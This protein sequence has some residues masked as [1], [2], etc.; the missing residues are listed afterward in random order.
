MDWRKFFD[1][2]AEFVDDAFINGV[3][4]GSIKLNNEKKIEQ[5]NKALDRKYNR[6]NK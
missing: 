1:G 5:Y 4:D 6:K 2:V 3:K